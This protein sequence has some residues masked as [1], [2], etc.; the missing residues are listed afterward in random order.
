MTTR[1]TPEKAQQQRDRYIL[2]AAKADIMDEIQTK[3]KDEKRWKVM[4]KYG[5]EYSI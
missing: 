1:H 2:T 3:K 4:L 5:T